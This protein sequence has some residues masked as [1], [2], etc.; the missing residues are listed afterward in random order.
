MYRDVHFF[1]IQNAKW[2]YL[3]STLCRYPFLIDDCFI[4]T[5]KVSKRTFFPRFQKIKKIKISFSILFESFPKYEKNG[6][7][8]R[9]SSLPRLRRPYTDT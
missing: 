4:T 3:R 7:D 2:F 1:K 5:S 8:I 6:N 9:N